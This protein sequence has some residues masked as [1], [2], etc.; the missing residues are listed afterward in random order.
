MARSTEGRK[1]WRTRATEIN[2][3]L[4]GF[5][6]W[7]A[8]V[9]GVAGGGSSLI[10]GISANATLREW[11]LS[12]S[13]TLIVVIALLTLAYREWTRAKPTRVADTMQN[14]ARA[15]ELLRDLHVFLRNRLAQ[16]ARGETLSRDAISQARTCIEEI[17]T[18]YSDVYSIIT[19]TKCRLSI[20]MIDFSEIGSL[21]ADELNMEKS[22]YV[23]TLARDRS[24]KRENK[25]AD[26]QREKEK[27]DRLIENTDFVSLWDM[28]RDDGG[29]FHSPDLRN[30]KEYESSSLTFWR[31]KHANPG[32]VAIEDWPLPYRSTIVWPIRQE[33]RAELGLEEYDTVG[34]LAVDSPSPGAFD[35]GTNAPIGTI[36]ANGL[37]PILK[38]YNELD[39]V[40]KRQP[41]GSKA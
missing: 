16:S 29:F 40:L 1:G 34:F 35:I 26:L 3:A 36:L 2:Y 14:Q 28:T 19:A 17:L 13:L 27:L 8:A 4:R 30:E 20:K 38:L 9:I 37:H 41:Q 33:P 18:I 15:S 31:T 11:V 25:N 24:S 32:S 21:T 39:I 12:L 6:G 23:F 5:L 22:I 7:L 10:V